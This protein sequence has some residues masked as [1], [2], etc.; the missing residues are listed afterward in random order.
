M[1]TP[2]HRYSRKNNESKRTYLNSWQNKWSNFVSMVSIRWPII[3]E[4]SH[5]SKCASYLVNMT[6][7]SLLPVKYLEVAAWSRTHDLIQM[8]LN[9]VLELE[10]C[11]L[12][13]RLVLLNLYQGQQFHLLIFS[14]SLN[15]IARFFESNKISLLNK[16][17]FPFF[18]INVTLL[19][20][21]AGDGVNCI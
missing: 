17:L 20:L 19:S 13:C 4:D 6:L 5:E 7:C 14:I 10:A 11:F 21:E 18:L 9:S 16:Y 12:S 8:I 1:L 2:A 3:A 15:T